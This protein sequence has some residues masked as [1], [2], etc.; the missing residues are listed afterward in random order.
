[1]NKQLKESLKH[2]PWLVD[3][4][5]PAESV[6]DYLNRY[7]KNERYKG[8][9]KE[10]ADMLL[11]GYKEGLEEDGCVRTSKHES[12]TGEYICWWPK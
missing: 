7:Y 6:E 5:V 11:K 3:C 10:Y 4:Y 12:V 8:R 1:M 2:W 9:G